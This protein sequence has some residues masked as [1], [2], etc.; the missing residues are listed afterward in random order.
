MEA[1]EGGETMNWGNIIFVFAMLS[2][3][4]IAGWFLCAVF[5]SGRID[6]LCRE[7]DW[8]RMEVMLLKKQR[9]QN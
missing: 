3:G 9:E 6:D 1:R 5:T 2:A 7:R 8:A 4:F